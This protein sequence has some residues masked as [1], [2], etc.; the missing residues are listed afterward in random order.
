[1]DTD[2]AYCRD[3]VERYDRDRYI[4][5]LAAPEALRPALWAVYAFAHEIAK[6]R[7]VTRD[8]TAGHVRLAWWR[9]RLVDFYAGAPMPA[10]D[11]AR[12][13]GHAI[14]NYALDRT[15]FDALLDAR[16]FDMDQGAPASI[17]GLIAYA[18]ATNTPLVHL[19][20]QILGS[21]TPAH[22]GTAWGLTGIIRAL[23]W[24]SAQ[25]RCV[26]PMPMM[27]DIG[28]MPEQFHHLKTS[29]ALSACVKQIADAAQNALDF[30]RP[31][32]RL[33]RVQVKMCGLYLKSIRSAGY[34]PFALQPVP[35]LALRAFF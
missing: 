9:E 32:A 14:T 23:P 10:H 4:V 5:T 17:D 33:F 7:E 29:P 24:L 26:L 12:A 27:H 30:E 1:M 20:A 22:L 2:T 6:T 3:Q 16:S 18:G 25:N 31:D 13:L 11:V 35:F 28:L 21:A 8:A 15:A 19:T 34:D